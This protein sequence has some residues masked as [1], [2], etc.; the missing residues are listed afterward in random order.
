MELVGRPCLAVYHDQLKTNDDVMG[1]A[2]FKAVSGRAS[3]IM[4][5]MSSSTY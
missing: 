2:D 4:P 3:Q 5:A 1:T